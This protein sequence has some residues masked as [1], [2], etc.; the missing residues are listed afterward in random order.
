VLSLGAPEVLGVAAIVPGETS[1]VSETSEVLR[2]GMRRSD[3]VEQAAMEF[4]MAYE[5][6]RG[7]DVEDV[8]TEGRGYDLLSR[9]PKEQIRYI[10]IKG[11]AATGAVELSANEWLKAEQLG[12]DYWLYIVTN[13]IQS[14]SLHLVQDPAHQLSEQEVA[15][16]VRYR[17]TQTGWHRAAE[18]GAEYRVE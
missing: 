4:A 18:S 16:R 17:V 10:E 12:E 8:H 9:G 11:R 13:A 7:W 5:R 2:A 14:P 1:E 3:A 15:P 6:D